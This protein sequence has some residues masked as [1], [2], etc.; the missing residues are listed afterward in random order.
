L[1]SGDSKDARNRLISSIARFVANLQ[2]RSVLLENVPGLRGQSRYLS[3]IATLRRDYAVREYVVD[4][5]DFGVPQRRRRVIVLA[6]R[7]GAVPPKDLREVLPMSF[8]RSPR[9]AGQALALLEGLTSE[10]DPIH[11]A[12]RSTSKTIARIRAMRQGG[13]RRELPPHLVLDCH[14]RLETVSATSIY[15]RL[16]PGQPA[17]TMTTRCTTPS[18]G[19]FA[20]PTEDRGLTL[21]EAAVL[22]TFPVAYKFHG[23]Y[24]DIERQIGNAVPPRLTEALGLIVAGLLASVD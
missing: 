17:P 23:G 6:V 15:G 3:L 22:Q 14:A 13:G 16:D 9:S 1:G 21:R 19:R 18:C 20:H 11:R 4:A 7:D 24:G 2:P 12:R 8:D 5:A 10:T